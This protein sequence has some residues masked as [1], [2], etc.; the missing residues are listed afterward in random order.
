MLFVWLLLL[1]ALSLAPINVKLMLGTMGRFHSIGHLLVFGITAYLCL[2]KART[3]GSRVTYALVLLALSAFLELLETILYH[4]PFEWRDLGLDALAITAV[5]AG[6]LAI[7]APKP[8]STV[9]RL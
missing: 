4:N 1:A 7:T 3:A 8:S 9:Q 2:G 5:L 6:F